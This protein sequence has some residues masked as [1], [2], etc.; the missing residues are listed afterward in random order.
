MR[1]RFK[2]HRHKTGLLQADNKARNMVQSLFWK[3]QWLIVIDQH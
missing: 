3:D 2:A 1:Q